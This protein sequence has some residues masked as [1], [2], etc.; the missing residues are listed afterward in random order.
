MQYGHALK[1]SGN[2][3]LAEAAYRRSIALAEKLAD[4]HLQLGH[5][6]K[7][8][9]RHDEA[10]S[11]YVA[12]LRHDPRLVDA[13][14]ELVRL[15]WST[16]RIHEHLGEIAVR[17]RHPATRQAPLAIE[18][19]DL[20]HHFLARGPIL[21]GIQRV[22]FAFLRELL[23]CGGKIELTVLIY[24]GDRRYWVAIS[25]RLARDL[26]A[27]DRD[28]AEWALAL[29]ELRL[30][31]VAGAPHVF[32][33]DTALVNVGTSWWLPDYFL[34][35][36]NARRTSGVRFCH[37]VHDLVPVLHPELCV[38]DVVHDFLPWLV[39]LTA[40]ADHLLV[41]SKA[42]G[43][44]L[45][46]VFSKLGAA[47]PP[48]TPVPLYGC[49]GGPSAAASH[50]I[51]SPL[52]VGVDRDFVLFVSTLEPRKNHIFVFAAWDRLLAE[53][54]AAAT[55]L[56]V[57]VGRRGW[58]F[59]EIDLALCAGG[60]LARQVRV[61]SDVSDAELAELYRRCR[62]TVYPSLYEGWGL[63]VSE[64]LAH[65]KV[66]LIARVAALPEAGGEFAE[67][68]DPQNATDFERKLTRLM[69]DD[70]YREARERQIARAY[71]PRDNREI[72]WEIVEAVAGSRQLAGASPAPLLSPVLPLDVYLPLAR[73]RATDLRRVVHSG[74]IYRVGTG[75][76]PPDEHGCRLRGTA[77][78][79]RMRISDISASGHILY[80]QC[81]NTGDREIQLNVR[82]GSELGLRASLAAGTQRC[83]PLPLCPDRK[84]ECMVQVCVDEPAPSEPNRVAP[85]LSTLR[86]IGLY[87]CRYA[88][89]A[90]HRR[91]FEHV[92]LDEL[93]AIMRSV[94][95]KQ[96]E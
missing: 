52:E 47:L 21:S 91:L 4:T 69:D 34:A 25:H 51:R 17:P 78:E 29:R 3:A 71:R 18:V 19:T 54:G 88:D 83:I 20:L 11:A 46:R 93:L 23:D 9:S 86:L 77:A 36:R 28:R 82:A 64:S 65:G 43:N 58:M 59:E 60:G 13:R 48:V 31:Y 35:L 27:A 72:A 49:I 1:E 94:V 45:I 42:T 80:L 6:L 7:L 66:P 38:P 84:G 81:A 2:L 96:H 89:E 40:H 92:A 63:P 55:P 32:Q 68:F 56:L 87:A 41:N 14:E 10:C 79:L 53:R 57:C 30:L 85:D 74:G 61:L 33:S 15:G 16:D 50:P 26:T 90:S 75:W 24:V 39:E 8:Q 70:A 95:T 62:F 12:A 73:N 37:F 22:Q 5:V 67:Y 76:E 44:D